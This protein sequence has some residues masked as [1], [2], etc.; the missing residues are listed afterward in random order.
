MNSVTP[1]AFAVAFL[2]LCIDDGE[3]AL[4]V[5]S[6]LLTAAGYHV[7]TATSGEHGLEL[8]KQHPVDLVVADHF[9]SGKTGTETAKAMKELKPEVPILIFSGSVDR[10]DGIECADEFLT[11][12]QPPNILLGT[13]ARLL[14][15]QPTIDL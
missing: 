6:L 4:R 2:I 12:C 1:S 9:L 3:V 15:K 5:R 10:P 13:I 11:K 7:L 8:F 14:V